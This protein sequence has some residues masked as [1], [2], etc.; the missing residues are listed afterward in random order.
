MCTLLFK[1]TYGDSAQHIGIGMIGAFAVGTNHA[2]TNDHTNDILHILYTLC[3]FII[4]NT[5]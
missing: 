5:Q 1:A 4:F 2:N 3:T